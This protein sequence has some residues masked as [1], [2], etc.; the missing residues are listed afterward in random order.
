MS[1]HIT[2]TQIEERLLGM[3]EAL[4]RGEVE[5]VSQLWA[6]ALVISD[7]LAG[8]PSGREGLK[9]RLRMWESALPDLSFAVESLAVTGDEA[10]VTLTWSGTHLGE[11][12]GV[13]GTGERVRFTATVRTIWSGGLMTELHCSSDWPGD[14]AE[15]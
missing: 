7:S 10:V 5:G 13:P 11:L 14:F 9:L 8:L 2:G 12:L 4:N 3:V 6:E 1:D 15:R